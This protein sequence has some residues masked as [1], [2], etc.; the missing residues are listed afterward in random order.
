MTCDHLSQRHLL[1]VFLCVRT[2][3]D[4]LSDLSRLLLPRACRWSNGM[5]FYEKPDAEKWGK[6]YR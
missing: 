4:V 2:P 1:C 5:Q 6:Y 3:L